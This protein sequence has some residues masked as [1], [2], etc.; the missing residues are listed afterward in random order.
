MGT[1]ASVLLFV[2]VLTLFIVAGSGCRDSRPQVLRPVATSREQVQGLDREALRQALRRLASAPAPAN[3]M[4]AMCYAP[5]DSPDRVEYVCPSCTRRTVYEQQLAP[6]VEFEVPACRR[7]FEQVSAL[8]GNVAHLDESQ[9]CRACRPDIEQPELL[10]TLRYADG[11]THD[12]SGV[13]QEDVRLLA[14]FLSGSRG[15]KSFNDAQTPL[16]DKLPRLE[17]L[18]GVKVQHE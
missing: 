2:A 13:T 3:T 17:D 4:G 16:K 1:F 15:H 9:F 6:L 14:E 12:V 10:L 8:L 7:E 5:R 18:L 11:Q